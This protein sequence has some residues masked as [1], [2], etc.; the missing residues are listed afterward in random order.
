ML[1]EM[2][3]AIGTEKC[4]ESLAESQVIPVQHR[5]VSLIGFI[6]HKI[7]LHLWAVLVVRVHI[8]KHVLMCTHMYTCMHDCA[9]KTHT[10]FTRC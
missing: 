8:H 10:Y 6:K 5:L 9:P 4:W 2:A 1:G 7:M 3:G